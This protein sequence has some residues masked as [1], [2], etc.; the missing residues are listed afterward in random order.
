MFEGK[1]VCDCWGGGGYEWYDSAEK[2]DYVTDTEAENSAKP[3]PAMMTRVVVNYDPGTQTG[4]YH[5]YKTFLFF[6]IF[7]TFLLSQRLLFSQ[8]FKIGKKTL[9]K[10]WININKFQRE[11]RKMKAD[12]P[13]FVAKRHCSFMAALPL[14]M[15]PFLYTPLCRRMTAVYFV[16]NVY[17]RTF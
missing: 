4:Y 1:V 3:G 7:V 16:H 2:K 5:R 11:H 14:S 10:E 13:V 17:S 9:H 8:R 6:F 12:T 15:L